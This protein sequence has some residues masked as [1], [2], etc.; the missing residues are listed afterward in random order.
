MAF[1]TTG[2]LDS[3]NAGASQNLTARAGWSGSVLV[4]ASTT[5]VTDAGP[6]YAVDDGANAGSNYWNTQWVDSECWIVVK[7]Y[8]GAVFY[9]DGRITATGTLT[10][11]RLKYDGTNLG[12]EKV[13][14]GVATVI[15]ATSAQTV[16][17]GDS[18]GLECNGTAIKGYYKSGAGAW[19]EV[20]TATDS[21]ITATGNIGMQGPFTGGTGTQVD[22]FNGGAI[23]VP[24]TTIVN[25]N[26]PV[27]VCRA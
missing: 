24:V 25:P 1:P 23:V 16:V 18:L 8:S 26:R 17:A 11:Y 12:L 5:M 21:A 20:C 19:T 9:L 6:T 3:F 7:S 27:I 2:L 13:I 10:A 15:G 22:D 14:A 4:T